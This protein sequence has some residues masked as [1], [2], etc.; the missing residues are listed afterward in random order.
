MQKNVIVFDTETN[1]LNDCSVLSVSAI[2]IEVDLELKCCREI[3]KFNRFYFRN[4]DEEI[5]ETAIRINK[6]TDEKI[7]FK[8][9]GEDYP[10]YFLKDD[11]FRKFCSETEYFVAHNIDFDSK[12]LP[13][14][15]EHKFC[16]QKSNIDIIKK[17]SGTKGKYKYPSLMETAEFYDIKLDK[18]QWHGSEYDTYIC[19]EI[20]MTMLK[21]KE[22]SATI[23]KFL[24][25]E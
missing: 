15:L 20:F 16:T 2:K 19:K 1:G 25:G 14:K 11:R 3:K 5:N 4:K 6:L 12:F 24:K 22:T 21:S 7:N 18:S 17:E 13:F 23:I 8:R 10:K 9:Q